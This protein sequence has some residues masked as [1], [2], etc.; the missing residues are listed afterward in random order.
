MAI[1]SQHHPL[2]NDRFLLQAD[3]ASSFLIYEVW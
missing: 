2:L 3:A 1:R